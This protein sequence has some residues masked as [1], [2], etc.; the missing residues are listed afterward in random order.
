MEFSTRFLIVGGGA[1]GMAAI[2]GIRTL[3]PGSPIL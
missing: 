1:A 3:D 2:E